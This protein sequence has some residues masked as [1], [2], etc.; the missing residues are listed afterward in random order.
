MNRQAYRYFLPAVII[1]IF[2]N[3]FA[4]LFKSKLESWGFDSS[5]VIP[6][7]LLLF[8]I[9]FISFRM[10]AKGLGSKSNPLFFRMVYGSFILK[11]L[12]LAAAAFI[13]IMSA[14]KNVNKP[15]LFLCMGLYVVYTFIEVSAL[16]K[17]G[18]R[19]TNA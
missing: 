5:V 10:G 12:L 19:K 7:N 1:F 16:M 13:Y 6:G 8:I 17:T 9:S 3:A 2:L 14:K 11:L 4:L 18:K 15:A